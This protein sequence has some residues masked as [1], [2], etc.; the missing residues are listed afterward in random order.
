MGR[1]QTLT[2]FQ[3]MKREVSSQAQFRSI[4]LLLLFITITIYYYY[5][6]LLLLFITITITVFEQY[7]KTPNTNESVAKVSIKVV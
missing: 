7:H 6:L 5:C 3:Q 2:H 4:L 1:L